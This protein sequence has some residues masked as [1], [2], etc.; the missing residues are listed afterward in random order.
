MT[1]KMRRESIIPEPAPLIKEIKPEKQLGTSKASTK[2]PERTSIPSTGRIATPSQGSSVQ[3]SA[4]EPGSKLDVDIITKKRTFSSA[5]KM[6][7][8][9][10]SQVYPQLPKQSLE[11]TL[12]CPFC[13]EQLPSEMSE[14][15]NEDSWK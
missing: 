7:K 3:R 10:A 2:G 13:N 14:K 11:G 4:T 8:I 6:T 15:R 1:R 9:G 12:I 5:T